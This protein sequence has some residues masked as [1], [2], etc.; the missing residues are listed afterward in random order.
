MKIKT[1]EYFERIKSN[2][3]NTDKLS[4]EGNNGLLF[5][6]P[7]NEPLEYETLV[8]IVKPDDNI[9]DRIKRQVDFKYTD[10][11]ACYALSAIFITKRDEKIKYCYELIFSRYAYK[12]ETAIFWLKY[13]IK[14]KAL[15][16]EVIGIR[17][18]MKE[19]IEGSGDWKYFI[20]MKEI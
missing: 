5:L 11:N 6:L 7:S 18:G 19:N 2:T 13:V 20:V 17:F 4:G 8:S 10:S 3:L 14:K 15:K 1:M 9:I 16:D 12:K